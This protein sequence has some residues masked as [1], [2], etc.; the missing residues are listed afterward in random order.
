MGFFHAFALPLRRK[1]VAIPEIRKLPRLLHAQGRSARERPGL[2]PA[3]NMIFRPEEEHGLSIED[4]VVP[5]ASGRKGEMH[6]A[7]GLR[8]GMPGVHSH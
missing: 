3:F 2:A 1:A 4:D 5:P 6:N 7:G 8:Y